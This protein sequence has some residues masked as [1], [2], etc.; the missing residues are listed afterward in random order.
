[1]IGCTMGFGISLCALPTTGGLTYLLI[2]GC[3]TL[4][5]VSSAFMCQSVLP[6]GVSSRALSTILE[7][8]L[9]FMTTAIKQTV[10]TG[11]F[12]HLCRVPACWD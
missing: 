11:L 7:Q 5:V 4:Q 12:Q 8:I 10:N 3:A 2:W 1:M 6:T 9:R